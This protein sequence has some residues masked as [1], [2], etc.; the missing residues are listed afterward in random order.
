MKKCSKFK[1]KFHCLFK[2]VLAQGRA[3]EG[4]A[5]LK[6]RSQVQV[7]SRLAAILALWHTEPARVSGSRTGN[8]GGHGGL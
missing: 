2:D 6:M 7:T 5:D 4:R 1:D 8:S 3:S